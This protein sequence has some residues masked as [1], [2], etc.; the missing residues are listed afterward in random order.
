[1]TSKQT[2]RDEGGPYHQYSS[3]DSSTESSTV[4]SRPDTPGTDGSVSHTRRGRV[5]FN[6]TSEANDA[7]N[8]RSSVPLRDRSL[9]PSN[10]TKVKLPLPKTA[11]TSPLHSRNN[12]ITSLL[13]H[14]PD[15]GDGDPFADHSAIHTV[16]TARP[17]MLMNMGS[18]VAGDTEEEHEKIFSALAAQERA[19][20][21]ASL[22]G[23]HSAPASAR[24]SLDE[25]NSVPDPSRHGPYPVRIDDI[26]LVE[27]DSKRVYDNAGD[28]EED[29][30]LGTRKPKVS[31][32]TKAH[33]LV[34]AHTRK[35]ISRKLQLEPSSP[36]LVSGQATPTEDQTFDEYVPAP[37]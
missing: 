14:T 20:R 24:T 23:S 22:V 10:L 5:R 3:L 16:L 4:P 28:S 9:S 29:L 36:G 12:S 37:Q 11:R 2:I 32:T 18:S 8:K 34:R 26:P 25:D 1:M 21:I 6:S 19:Q 27:M 17:S 33:K 7:A 13:R 35:R 15:Q 31:S 30:E